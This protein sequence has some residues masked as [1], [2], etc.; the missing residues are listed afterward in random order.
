MR[1]VFKINKFN[2]KIIAKYKS[3][4]QAA[5]ENYYTEHQMNRMLIN[6]TLTDDGF[7]FRY[8]DDYKLPEDWSKKRGKPIF[9]KNKYTGEIRKYNNAHDA[10]QDLCRGNYRTMASAI[11]HGKT[12]GWEWEIVVGKGRQVELK[13]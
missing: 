12:L 6:K 9:V 8:A 10:A 5:K 4:R 1:A 11:C 2:H 7:Y 3:A 13:N